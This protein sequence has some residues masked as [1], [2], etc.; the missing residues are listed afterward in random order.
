MGPITKLILLAPFVITTGGASVARQMVNYGKF[1]DY[2]TSPMYI[3]KDGTSEA[4]FAADCSS[5]RGGANIPGAQLANSQLDF[6]DCF[7]NEDGKLVPYQG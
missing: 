7:A 5:K 3:N 4:T 6:N 2:C 1:S